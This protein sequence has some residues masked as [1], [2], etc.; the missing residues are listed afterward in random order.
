MATGC[1]DTALRRGGVVSEARP[2][3]TVASGMRVHRGRVKLTR[4]FQEPRVSVEFT[5]FSE[6][7]SGG[8][9]RA[10]GRE[11]SRAVYL[12]PSYFF[13]LQH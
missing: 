9:R 13:V 1:G 8:G 7:G 10:C 3:R 5:T 6:A 11:G 4:P 12:L 2:A